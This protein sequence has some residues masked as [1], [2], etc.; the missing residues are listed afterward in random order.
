MDDLPP[1]TTRGRQSEAARWSSESLPGPSAMMATASAA[2]GRWKLAH[3]SGTT[4][5]I[6][7][8]MTRSASALKRVAN[9]RTSKTGKTISAMPSK[10]ANT[11]G[12][13]KSYTCPKMCSLNSSSK[14]YDAAGDRDKKPSHFVN[15]DL[16]NGSA[17][18]MQSSGGATTRATCARSRT[19]SSTVDMVKKE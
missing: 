15:P 5:W 12:K 10:Y 4:S 8:V 18:A 2:H 11:A 7:P 17:R 3:P 9:P 1:E 6:T 14:R 16:K 13:G 19:T